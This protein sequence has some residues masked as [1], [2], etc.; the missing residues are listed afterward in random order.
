MENLDL[1]PVLFQPLFDVFAMMNTKI[2]QNQKDLSPG[3]LD[4]AGHELDQE[5]GIHGFLVHHESHLATVGDGRYHT[6]MAL[7][8]NH[9]DYQSLSLWGKASDSVGTRLN[10][11]LIHP[12]NLS[13]FLFRAGKNDRI[14]PIQPFLHRLRTL[15]MGTLDRLLRSESPTLEIFSNRPDRHLDVKQLPDQQLHRIP[16]P[17]CKRKLQLVRCL[18]NQSFTKLGLLIGRKRPLFPGSASSFPQFDG[19]ATFLFVALLY[20]TG[21]TYTDPKAFCHNLVLKISFPKTNHL[22]SDFILRLLTMLTCINLFHECCL[23][24]NH[25]YGYIYLPR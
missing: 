13:F 7:F 15:F 20:L 14:I 25:H 2:I 24:Q 5:L 19:L 22:L 17:Q 4:Q 1:F 11:C 23:S 12:V 18:V 10:T 3:I 6:D 8:G 16:R 21:P 9:P